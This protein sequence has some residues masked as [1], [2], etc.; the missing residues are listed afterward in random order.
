MADVK[1]GD[2]VTWNSHGGEAK[3]KIEKK[4]TRDTTIKGHKARATP[5]DPQFI[6]RSE[7]GSGKAAHK[8]GALR[9]V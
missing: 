7:S 5:D 1:V 6:V 2:T 8:P 4:I 9:K 3:G